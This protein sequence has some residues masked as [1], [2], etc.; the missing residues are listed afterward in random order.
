MSR[1]L[2]LRAR[3]NIDYSSEGKSE[4]ALTVESASKW[5]DDTPKVL[6]IEVK[7]AHEMFP[8][9]LNLP[10]EATLLVIPE[11]ING[12]WLTNIDIRT[13]NCNNKVKTLIGKIRKVFLSRNS[14]T[15]IAVDGFMDSLLHILRFDDYPCFL[16]PQYNYSANIGPNNYPVKAKPDFSVLSEDKIMLVIEDKTITSAT[17]ANRWKEDQ[18]LGELFT[19]VHFVVAESR[20]VVT[21]PVAVYAVRV[22]GTKFTFYRAE[23]TLEY[24]KH[25]ARMGPSIGSDIKMVVQ[26]YPQV[27][28]DPSRLTA[29]DICDKDHRMRILECLCYIRESMG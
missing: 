27:E 25:S 16:Y 15:E 22:V 8:K 4:A 18:V 6:N 1:R 23:A 28:D 7:D 29:Y 21:Y 5:G 2:G 19:A 24:I 12:R 11:W 14:M 20:S 3:S 9:G 26:R 17:Y 10:S 13:L